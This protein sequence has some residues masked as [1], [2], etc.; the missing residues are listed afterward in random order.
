MI[1]DQNTCSDNF[2]ALI[3]CSFINKAIP[4]Q[5]FSWIF[6]ETF[7]SS[8]CSRS[9]VFFTIG[10]LKNVANFTGKHQCW[11]LFSKKVAG[12]QPKSF[13]NTIFYRALSMAASGAAVLCYTCKQLVRKA[14]KYFINTH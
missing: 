10:V 8:R 3:T 7:Q 5:P 14:L 1:N 13:K 11:S 4:P 9:H 2:L 12:L 6:C